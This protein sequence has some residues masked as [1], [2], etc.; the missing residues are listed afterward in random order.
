M[1]V[2]VQIR[3]LSKDARVWLRLEKAETELSDGAFGTGRLT[4][5]WTP[6]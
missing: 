2:R 1:S 4:C 3:S 6:F 5:T